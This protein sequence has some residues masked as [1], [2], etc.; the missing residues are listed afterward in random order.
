[1]G[2]ILKGIEERNYCENENALNHILQ[3]F[4][5]AVEIAEDE[6]LVESAL[7]KCTQGNLSVTL[8]IPENRA[9]NSEGKKK[10]NCKDC[11]CSDNIY[12]FGK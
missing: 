1:M 8:E 6:Y 3:K 2:D 10:A 11:R 7:L 9:V 12:Y 4:R 5:D